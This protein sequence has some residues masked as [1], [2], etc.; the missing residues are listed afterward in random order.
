MPYY[1]WSGVD[2]SGKILKGTQ[3][4]RSTFDLDKDLFSKE[5]ALLKA[6][7][8]I[9]FNLYIKFIKP[10]KYVC[11][12]AI[13]HI[14]ILLKSG[15]KIHQALD[16][17]SKNI[18]NKYFKTI[19]KDIERYVYEGQ[20]LSQALEFHKNIFSLLEKSV[21]YSGEISSN[22]PTAFKELAYHNNIIEKFK[23]K[24]KSCLFIPI[25]TLIL[26]MII[27]F[28]LFIFVIP[29]FAV[30]FSSIDKNLI[31]KS[32]LI[33]LRLS[34]LINSSKIFYLPLTIIFLIAVFNIFKLNIV[35]YT[36]NNILFKIPVISRFIFLIYQ[37]K[38]LQKL[39]LLLT[40]QIHISNALEII[41]KS[42][43]NNIQ[44]I[45][46]QKI[47][48]QIKS[49][50][51]LSHAFQISNIFNADELIAL[52]EVGESSGNLVFSINQASKIYQNRVYNNLNKI[53]F[54]VQPLLL[55]ILGILISGLILS[56]YIPIFTL[57]SVIK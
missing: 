6:T 2:L 37:A 46:I 39:N 11:N 27:L 43:T 49:G 17:V 33:I 34:L 29:K 51:S 32:T 54:L 52:I 24:I 3:F 41:I 35:N 21:I 5:I 36:Q 42:T 45:E 53:T 44:K 16:I 22:L 25:I 7:E 48:D 14:S 30:F 38:F 56:I 31:P 40:S 15:L 12:Q 55:I 10:K 26:F 1:Y 4:A 20:T 23:K 13:E 28:S 8:S 19:L 50:K 57:S 18:K 9:W 47:L